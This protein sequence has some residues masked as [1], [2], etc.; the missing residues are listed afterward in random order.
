MTYEEIQEG[1]LTKHPQGLRLEGYVHQPRD[2]TDFLDSLLVMGGSGLNSLWHTYD[3]VTNLMYCHKGKNRSQGDIFL[4]T[5]YYYPTITFKA[6]K[7]LI[8]SSDKRKWGTFCGHIDKQVIGF[9]SNS[10]INAIIYPSTIDNLKWG[11]GHKDNAGL[12]EYG[13]TK[14]IEQDA[15]VNV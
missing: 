10:D 13:F 4:I 1:L 11:K 2:I 3:P 6:V 9:I 14:E 7:H 5:R 12:D 8:L 15:E